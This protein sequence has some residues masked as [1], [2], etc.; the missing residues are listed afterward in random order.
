M[1]KHKKKSKIPD[2]NEEI[3]NE[4]L[5]KFQNAKIYFDRMEIFKSMLSDKHK[6]MALESIPEEERHLYLHHIKSADAIMSVFDKYSQNVD[7]ERVFE[8]L[9]TRLKGNADKYLQLL[10]MVDFKVKLNPEIPVIKL[11][12]LN[13]LNI[14][15]LS[16]IQKNVSD[17]YNMKFKL[18]ERAYDKIE[19]T[20]GEMCAIMM[21][22]Q[23]LTAGIDPN[24]SEMD[25]FS[26]IYERM[27][28]MIT[29]DH[30]C[31]TKTNILEDIRER[32]L[33]ARDY[34]SASKT[35]EKFLEARRDAAGL[36]GG[37]VNGKAICAGYSMILHEALQYVGIKSKYIEGHPKYDSQIKHAHAWNQVK[38]EGKWYN[39]DSTWDAGNL[40][41]IGFWRFALLDDKAFKK[42]HIDFPYVYSEHYPC[43]DPKNQLFGPESR[44]E[45]KGG[46]DKWKLI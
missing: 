42:S 17:Y 1:K 46:L 16:N 35:Y 26:I 40:Q 37:L 41:Q 7:K 39:V 3:E 15:M 31:I 33:E 20:F 43:T 45:T 34:D 11:N 18:N 24:A 22:L 21:K 9:T 36:F 23:E 28:S 27:T 30:D 25:K 38:I 8:F 6:V 2:Y 13:V 14:D 12:N 5:E 10:S 29:Y 19:Y 32:E 44:L 4:K